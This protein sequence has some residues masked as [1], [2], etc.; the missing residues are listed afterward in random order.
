ML[1]MWPMICTKGPVRPKQS[2]SLLTTLTPQQAAAP[3]VLFGDE[4]STKPKGWKT[5]SPEAEDQVQYQAWTSDA[6]PSAELGA[7]GV[8]KVT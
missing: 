7:I 1:L 4:D 5:W 8:V 6:T 2:R 3:W